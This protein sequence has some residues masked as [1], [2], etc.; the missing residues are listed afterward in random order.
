MCL[1]ARFSTCAWRRAKP[2]CPC[3]ASK[4]FAEGVQ[5]AERFSRG[6][7]RPCLLELYRCRSEQLG[8]EREHVRVMTSS[9]LARPDQ[10][11][12]LCNSTFASGRRGGR[13]T[14]FRHREHFSH[15]NA[16]MPAVV[17]IESGCR[18]EIGM[19]ELTTGS[20]NVGGGTDDRTKLLPESMQRLISRDTLASQPRRHPLEGRK[21]MFPSTTGVVSGSTRKRSTSVIKPGSTKIF[22]WEPSVLAWKYSWLTMRIS[23][24][25]ASNCDQHSPSISD[26]RKPAPNAS[27]ITFH[28][29]ASV[30]A[31]AY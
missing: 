8:L 4:T 22:P 20:V 12:N 7:G 29:S 5:V 21:G 15:W 13:L 10:T 23:P 26:R 25:T 30:S 16:H 11:D 6:P 28:A 9:A 18:S 24:W 19:P 1:S 17:S 27:R 3:S 2:G 14:R 31:R